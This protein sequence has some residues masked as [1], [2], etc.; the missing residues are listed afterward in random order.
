MGG[1]SSVPDRT[2][3]PERGQAVSPAAQPGG[4]PVS[5]S[6]W[7][8]PSLVSSVLG[9]YDL[10]VG[11]WIPG[12]FAASNDDF[13]LFFKQVFSGILRS[14]RFDRRGV[15]EIDCHLPV[16]ISRDELGATLNEMLQRGL[17]IPQSQSGERG[18]THSSFAVAYPSRAQTGG[19]ADSPL[20]LH[21]D[22]RLT[23][24]RG[25]AQTGSPS[26]HFSDPA[27]S[28][29]EQPSYRPRQQ[30][31]DAGQ[32]ST[33]LD[34]IGERI[35]N[36]QKP[37]VEEFQAFLRTLEGQNFGLEVNQCIAARIQEMADWLRLPFRCAQ[38]KEPCSLPAR[39]R[40]TQHE[41]YP[42]G[43]FQFEHYIPRTKSSAKK[44]P[45]H[46][47]WKAFPPLILLID[48]STE[49]RIDRAR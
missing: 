18:G 14:L 48:G 20:S 39:L 49:A 9:S 31:L 3:H 29:S 44:Q 11:D 37:V 15:I 25:E 24:P 46:G 45:K 1:I 32:A 7:K 33:K 47:A 4:E 38:K 28:R 21:L 19:A 41:Q 2:V 34:K 22:I 40:C 27:I 10:A 8:M 6:H 30:S 16:E 17:G 5:R 43:I 23:E 35:A 13:G 12:K 26:T 36:I 42:D